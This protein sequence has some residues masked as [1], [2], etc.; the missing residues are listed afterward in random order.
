MVAERIKTRRVE[1]QLT[2][3]DIAD[4]LKVT[5]QT[6]SKYERGINIPDAET[7]KSLSYILQ[8]STD[9]LVG[10]TDNPTVQ[11]I[12]YNDKELGPIEIG[13]N[14]YPYQL[15]PDEVEEMI[16]TL[17]RYH[18][19]VEAIIEDMRNKEKDNNTK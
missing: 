1:L 10:K 2:Q 6:I 7:L 17:K 11:V 12:E 19:N 9:Y 16:E 3:K 8:C 15:T 18:F 14:N 5:Y 4:R 13:M